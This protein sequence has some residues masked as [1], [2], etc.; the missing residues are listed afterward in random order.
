MFLERFI[1][2]H[3]Q[4]FPERKIEIKQKNLASPCFSKGLRYF[5]KRKQQLHETFS[6]HRSDKNYLINK[7][8]KNLF[9]KFKK[10]SK[11]IYFQDKSKQYERNIKNTW[12]VTKTVTGKSKISNDSFRKN[13]DINKKEIT[14]KKI[15]AETFDT[16]FI[17]AVSNLADKIPSSS[18]KFESYILNITTALIDT[19]LTEKE[20]KDDFF[21]MKTD[22]SPGYDNLHVNL[23]RST[24]HELKIP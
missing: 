19:P 9:E 15:I 7:I 13:L 10:K 12:N 8:Y 21:T 16:F 11:K 22:K 18:T 17:N 1:N 5:S 20:F 14:D 6:K 2:I 24:Y 3:D 23:I 4:R